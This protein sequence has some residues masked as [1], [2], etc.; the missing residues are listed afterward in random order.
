MESLVHD[1]SKSVEKIFQRLDTRTEGASHH[2]YEIIG[3]HFDYDHFEIRSRFEKSDAGPSRAMMEAIVARHP[4]FTVE[5]FARVVEE[6]TPRQDV[7]RRLRAY[8]RDLLN[9]PGD[10]SLSLE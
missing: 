9:E 4:E 7:A 3:N 8:D 6:K 10:L 5:E 1:L 2:D